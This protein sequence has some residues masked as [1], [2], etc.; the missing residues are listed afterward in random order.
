MNRA[1]QGIAVAS[2]IGAVLTHVRPDR[3]GAAA[4][5]LT[6]SQQFG[7]ASGVAVIGAIFYGALG[8]ATSRAAFVSG[9]VP[10][11]SADAGLAA[12]AAGATLLLPRSPGPLIRATA[13][14]ASAAPRTARPGSRLPGR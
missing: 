12:I 14:A 4:G 9:M 6:T 10:A 11:M 2:L 1:G 8:A 5:I 7:A 13:P 3:A